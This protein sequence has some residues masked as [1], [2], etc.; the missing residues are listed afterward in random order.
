VCFHHMEKGHGGVAICNSASSRC[1]FALPLCFRLD[2]IC[3]LQATR[4]TRTVL[5]VAYWRDEA[6]LQWGWHADLI[7]RSVNSR[8]HL[9]Q[10]FSETWDVGLG[11][12]TISPRLNH[13]DKHV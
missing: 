10:L 1:T 3:Y 13:G 4:W 8:Y 2:D 9:R 5:T 11:A 12:V 6:P 7:G